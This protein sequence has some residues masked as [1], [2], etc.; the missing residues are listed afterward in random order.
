MWYT[1][2]DKIFYSLANAGVGLKVAN[3]LCGWMPSDFLQASAYLWTRWRTENIFQMF[4]ILYK[5]RISISTLTVCL[6]CYKN[7][8]NRLSKINL[9]FERILYLLRLYNVDTDNII[10]YIFRFKVR[11]SVLIKI[12]CKFRYQFNCSLASKLLHLSSTLY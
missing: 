4:V 2:T 8:T 11:T 9:C 6:Y 5:N 10:W 3:I 1:E 12:L 7:E